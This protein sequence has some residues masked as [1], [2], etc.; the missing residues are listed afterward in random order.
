MAQ[1]TIRQLYARPFQI[2]IEEAGAENLMTGF[3]RIG[4]VWTSQHG[5]INNV[6]RDEFGMQGF[7]VS[8]Y[9][10]NGYMDLVGGIL[11]GCALPD[12]DTATSADKSALYNYKEGYGE[13]AW[14]MREEAHRIL[15]VVVNSIAMNGYSAST[16]FV[17]ITPQW[18]NILMG[19]RGGIIASFG[20]SVVIYVV[21]SIVTRKRMF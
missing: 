7:A 8:D 21:V 11:G 6:F 12:G 13:L 5:F 4:V 20:I 1:L 16:R 19:A 3:N 14:A 2:A 9:W 17:T 10:Q 18:V 15:Y